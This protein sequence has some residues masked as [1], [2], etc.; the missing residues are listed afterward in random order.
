M[1]CL[2]GG[3][4]VGLAPAAQAQISAA[5]GIQS[6]YRYRGV[7][8][9]NRGPVATLDLSYDHASGFY[10]GGSAIGE[11]EDGGLDTLGFIE[12]AGF[13]TPKWKGVA[14]DFGVNNQN[15]SY[16]AERRVPLNYS[17]VYV[18]VIGEH[19]SAHLHY[20][21]NYIRPGYDTLYA[22]VDGSMRPADNWRLFAHVGTTAPFGPDSAGRHQRYDLRAGVA[23]QFGS[24][25]LQASVTATTPAPPPLTPPERTALVFGASWFF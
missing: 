13:V 17:E 11:T 12:Y 9:S 10:V 8:L 15:L 16:Y 14:W 19:L 3:L 5:V 4:T 24:L 22:E 1:A 6:D 18:G 20:S 21:P 2:A 25:E 7:S 23:R